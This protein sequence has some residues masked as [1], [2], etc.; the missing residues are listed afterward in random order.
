[1]VLSKILKRT[2]QY[3]KENPLAHTALE[4]TVLLF[5]G[6]FIAFSIYQLQPLWFFPV[7]LL[8]IGGRYLLFKTIYG[9]KIYWIFGLVLILAGVGLMLMK[10]HFWMGAIIGG[11]IEIFFATVIFY[12]EKGET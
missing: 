8:I 1:M 3:K 4:S 10:Q 11:L 6:L 2:G 5:I 7:M 9:S 12:L